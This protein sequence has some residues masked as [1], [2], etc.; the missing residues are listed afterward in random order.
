MD[1]SA[2]DLTFPLKSRTAL[3]GFSSAKEQTRAGDP[4]SCR[5]LKT[6]TAP[7]SYEQR[8]TEERRAQRDLSSAWESGASGRFR[9]RVQASA[10][11]PPLHC[12]SGPS[13]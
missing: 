6:P 2:G 5:Y 13:R 7:S 1:L 4:I 3:P 12:P 9:R 10:R 11:A 8:L